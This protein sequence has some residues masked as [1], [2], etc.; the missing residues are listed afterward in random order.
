MTR[1]VRGLLTSALVALATQ[2]A[3]PAQSEKRVA[4]VIGNSSY[5]NVARLENPKNDAALIADTLGRLGF[6]LVGGGAQVDLDK[7][8]FDVA[9]QRFGNQLIGAD[10][11][12]FYY[13][14]HGIQLR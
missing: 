5:Q 1:I 14:G 3:T 2:I 12:L 11:G 7:P 9:V 8:A 6:T 10:V 13:A 4:L